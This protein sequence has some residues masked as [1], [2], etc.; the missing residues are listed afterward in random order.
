MLRGMVAFGAQGRTLEVRSVVKE[1]RVE[2]DRP[3]RRRAVITHLVR[4]VVKE[5]RVRGYGGRWG[6]GPYAFS[7]TCCKGNVC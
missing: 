2:G 6:V 4:P 5:T 7:T 3:S 1:T